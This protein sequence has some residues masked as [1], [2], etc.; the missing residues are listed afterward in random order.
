VDLVGE[1]CGR[2]ARERQAEQ[3]L[4][5]DVGRVA[6]EERREGVVV[7]AGSD[8]AQTAVETAEPAGAADERAGGRR[9]D[10]EG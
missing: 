3:S 7:D 5:D 10:A 2:L 4:G 6:A 8:R 1:P 9:G